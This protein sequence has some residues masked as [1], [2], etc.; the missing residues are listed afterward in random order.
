MDSL[1]FILLSMYSSELASEC[2]AWLEAAPFLNAEGLGKGVVNDSQDTVCYSYSK[3]APTNTTEK[4]TSKT[5]CIV[6]SVDI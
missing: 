3:A 6:T 4:G 2:A 5:Y 1:L